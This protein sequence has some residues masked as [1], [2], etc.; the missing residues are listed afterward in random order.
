MEA[1]LTERTGIIVGGR[2]LWNLRYADDTALLASSRTQVE[3]EAQLLKKHSERFELQINTSKT[4]SMVISEE[5]VQ[6]SPAVGSIA[7]NCV[8]QFKYLRSIVTTK[9]SCEQDIRA[10]LAIARHANHQF[11]DV[12]NSKDTSLCLKNRLGLFL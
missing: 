1:E 5:Q 9:G 7:I 12:W 10:R 4:V 8:Q 11:V 2:A 6:Q 3:R